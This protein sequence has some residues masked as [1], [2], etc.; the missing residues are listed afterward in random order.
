MPPAAPHLPVAFETPVMAATADIITDTDG[1]LLHSINGGS[2]AANG[3]T[4]AIADHRV[5]IITC[6]RQRIKLPRLVTA[7]TAA[8]PSCT[9]HI[10]DAAPM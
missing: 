7:N 10:G 4:I 1:W 3:H 2:A 6:S 9:R 8:T 5:D